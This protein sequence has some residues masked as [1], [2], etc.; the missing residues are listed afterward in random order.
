M[1]GRKIEQRLADWKNA[2]NHKP[3]IIKGCRQCGK[4]FSVLD[5]TKKNYKH[6]VYHVFSAI[7]MGDYNVGRSEQILTLPLYMAFLLDTV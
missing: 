4:T 1:L 5:F 6:V 7:K 2:V 3:L